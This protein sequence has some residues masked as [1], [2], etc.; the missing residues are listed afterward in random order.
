VSFGTIRHPSH[1]SG[2]QD[3]VTVVPLAELQDKGLD[4]KRRM[5]GRARQE[6]G[7]NDEEEGKDVMSTAVT[8]FLRFLPIFE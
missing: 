1:G 5:Q 8:A 7:D 2:R 6:L 4:R 3:V